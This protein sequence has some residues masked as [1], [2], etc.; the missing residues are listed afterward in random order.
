MGQEESQVKI[1][2]FDV[3]KPENPFEVAKYLLDEYW[4]EVSSTHHAFLLDDRHQVFFLPGGKGGYIFSYKDNLL[5]LTR[6]VSETNVRRAIYINDYLYIIGDDKIVVLNEA[7]WE[8][9]NELIF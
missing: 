6:A 1:S 8:K 2:L 4:T 7:D 9:V 5:N 3:T